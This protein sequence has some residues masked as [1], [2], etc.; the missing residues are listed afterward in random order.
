M[1]ESC[2]S[3]SI[4]L[5][6]PFLKGIEKDSILIDV[7]EINNPKYYVKLF[8]LLTRMRLTITAMKIIVVGYLSF[9]SI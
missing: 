3:V 8:R 7:T 4:Q 5:V 1:S 6:R 9:A 2:E